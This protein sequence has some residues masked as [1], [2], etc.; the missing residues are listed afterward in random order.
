VRYPLS[1]GGAAGLRIVAQVADDDC[2]LKHGYTSEKQ[3]ARRDGRA[4]VGDRRPQVDT[5]LTRNP[6]PVPRQEGARTG[7]GKV[8]H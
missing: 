1:R 2:L 6:E 7:A 5:R 3:K 4:R 8:K